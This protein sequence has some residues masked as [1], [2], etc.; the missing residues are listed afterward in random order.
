MTF[1]ELIVVLSIVSI[2]STVTL[3]NF[4]DFSTKVSLQNLAQDIA[5]H[6]KQS[7]TNSISGRLTEGFVGG[8]P[9][10]YG[11]YFNIDTPSSF[12]YFRDLGSPRNH[13]FD[14]G[15]DDLGESGSECLSITTIESQDYVSDIC[16]DSGLCGYDDLSVTFVRPF[17]EPKIFGTRSGT[18][19]ELTSGAQVEIVSPKGVNMHILVWP[20]GQISVQDGPVDECAGGVG[21]AC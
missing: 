17:P 7:Q 20:T 6:I 13:I 3:F 12:I 5:L 2:I 14:G 11:V 18:L 15:C 16:N 10:S 19:E 8:Q 4:T 1:I 21:A 9:P